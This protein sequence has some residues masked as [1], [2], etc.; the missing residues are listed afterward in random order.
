MPPVPS[1][2]A[3]E[4]ARPDDDEV[5]AVL[6]EIVSRKGLPPQPVG[7]AM[8]TY[9]PGDS[10]WLDGYEFTVGERLP[11]GTIVM[12]DPTTGKVVPYRRNP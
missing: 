3:E 8:T 7:A 6:K 9:E 10:V 2:A 1:G 12:F 4:E 11:V 5:E